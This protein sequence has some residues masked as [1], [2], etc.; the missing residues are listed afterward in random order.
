M[1]NWGLGDCLDR[2]EFTQIPLDDHQFIS[3]VCGRHHTLFLD[4]FQN[5]Y[6]CGSNKFGQLG[7]PD[8][9]QSENLILLEKLCFISVIACQFLK[10]FCVDSTGTLF[11]FGE[12]FGNNYKQINIPPVNFISSTLSNSTLVIDNKTDIWINNNDKT[13]K[14]FQQ[15]GM[16]Q[17]YHF[18]LITKTPISVFQLSEQTRNKYV[19]KNVIVFSEII[20]LT[21][22]N[23]LKKIWKLLIL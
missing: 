18:S 9:I 6:A 4:S 17:P 21:N 14:K 15:K 12:H 16:A 23:R 2:T 3:I 7:L 5:V 20:K 13:F 22:L 11:A 19:S 10:S 8:I 1:V